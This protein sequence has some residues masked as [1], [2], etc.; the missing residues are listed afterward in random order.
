MLEIATLG[1]LTLLFGG[2]EIVLQ[3]R[4]AKA[5]IGY[6][7]LSEAGEETR[8]RLVGL[9]WSEKAHLDA[10]GS[11]RQVVRAIRRAFGEAGFDG[12]LADKNT[13]DKF[14]LT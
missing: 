12:F 7:A 8:E 10:R 3:S 6:L 9:F 5:L 14:F 1:R 2:R 13:P 11:L 4:K